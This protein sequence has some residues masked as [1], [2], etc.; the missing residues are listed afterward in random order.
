MQITKNCI[1]NGM[2]EDVYHNDPT[3]LSAE[4]F[5]EYTSLSSSVGKTIVEKTEIEAR[6]EINRFNPDRKRK[7]SDTWIVTGK[8][9]L[10]YR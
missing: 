8:H 3:P 1:I 2:P 9:L 4:G 10:A 5:A 7:K 6:M